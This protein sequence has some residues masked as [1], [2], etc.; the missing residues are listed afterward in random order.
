M[1]LGV[2][3]ARPNLGPDW[4]SAEPFSVISLA[5]GATRL[6]LNSSASRYAGGRLTVVAEAAGYAGRDI[7][8]EAVA[9][10]YRRFGRACVGQLPGRF[11]F[12]LHDGDTGELFAASSTAPSWPLAYW[13]DAHT[14]VICSRLLPLLRHPDVPRSLNENYVVHLVMGLSAMADGTTPLRG[15]R[16]LTPGE[17]LVVGRQGARTSCVDRLSPREL[18]EPGGSLGDRFMDE[19][20]AAMQVAVAGSQSTLSFSGGLDSA[21]LVAA[22][23]RRADAVPAY[24]F[25]ASEAR[26]APEIPGIEAMQGAFAGLHLTR[27]DASGTADFPDLG[28][29]L[30]DDPPLVPLGLLSARIQLW[31]RA[32]AAGLRTVIEGEGGDELFSALPTPVDALRRGRVLAAARTFLGSSGRRKLVEHAILL[33]LLPAV[34]QRAWLARSESMDE[35]LPAFA[36][37]DARQHPL[38]RE[39]SDEYLASLVH[40]P[41]ADRLHQWLSAPIVVGAMA[42]RRHVAGSL[43]VELAWPMLERGVLELVMGLHARR[44]LGG[45]PQKP[46][47]RDALQGLVPDEVRLLPKDIGLYRAFI[48]R[49]LTSQRAREALRDPRVRARLAAL[50]RFERIE[51]MLDGLAT[52]RDLGISALWHLE[53][54]VSFAQWYAAAS[55]DYGVD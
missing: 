15:I 9:T 11:R 24:S 48:P 52:G 51:G 55:R 54:V 18:P 12:L 35:H 20:A 31:S 45:G 49:V 50:V 46:F 6:A 27:F 36:A 32:R 7:N 41:F 43:G 33:P 2:V 25:V 37:W 30:R 10:A 19:L 42:S 8:A 22:G 14:T 39:A 53:C 29:D 17:A 16:R 23:L 28:S 1:I 44:A 47:L 4:L 5:D 21:A 3:Q 13:S 34:M 26:G 38:V 40:R